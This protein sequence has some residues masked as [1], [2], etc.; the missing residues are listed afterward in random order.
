MKGSNRKGKRK[1][2]YRFKTRRVLLGEGHPVGH[3]GSKT[4]ALLDMETMSYVPL[5]LGPSLWCWCEG[6]PCEC[7]PWKLIL[8]Q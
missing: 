4:V 5:A 1:K 7:K 2:S 6:G 8:E 3:L